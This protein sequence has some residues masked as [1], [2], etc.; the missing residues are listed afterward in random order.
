MVENPVKEA[1]ME[2]PV[3]EAVMESPAKEAVM[4]SP[5]K[6]AVME[7]KPEKPPVDT[8][9]EV[10]S[11]QGGFL[12]TKGMLS[13]KWYEVTWPG[14]HNFPKNLIKP[15]KYKKI[16]KKAKDLMKTLGGTIPKLEKE[17]DEMFAN[18]DPNDVQKLKMLQDFYNAAN[19]AGLWKYVEQGASLNP[20]GKSSIG[21]INFRDSWRTLGAM[22]KDSKRVVLLIDF[23]A[24]KYP[25]VVSNYKFL[26]NG[27]ATNK[28]LLWLDYDPA[29]AAI[30]QPSKK[31]QIFSS[32]TLYANPNPGAYGSADK[33]AVQPLND[34]L[35][36]YLTGSKVAA[37]LIKNPSWGAFFTYYQVQFYEP[38][39]NQPNATRQ[40]MTVVDA[41]NRVNYEKFKFTWSTQ[42][43]KTLHWDN[44]TMYSI[45]AAKILKQS[46]LNL[47]TSKIDKSRSWGGTGETKAINSSPYD[48][49]TSGQKTG[50]GSWEYA[51]VLDHTKSY[52]P[53]TLMLLAQNV[54]SLQ[55]SGSTNGSKWVTLKSGNYT[56]VPGKLWKLFDLSNTKAYRY[57]RL[58]LKRK[59]TNSPVLL[60]DVK[61]LG[62]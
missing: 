54:A 58:E 19:K 55:I 6:E 8:K 33:A 22:L 62:H 50:G 40:G 11:K 12:F 52:T 18:K 42:Y 32:F 43:A 39:I 10:L 46:G 34:G 37:E 57:I 36:L 30:Q 60:H 21:Q 49:W 14:T 3:K 5:A 29:I 56:S 1:V 61:V 17:I 48:A 35:P 44:H 38:G 31:S 51:V 13:K 45:L 15:S 2:S 59:N 20:T 41:A 7:T 27:K 47:L 24:T 23:L 9:S 28:A 4:E 25:S 53:K 16:Y 26:K